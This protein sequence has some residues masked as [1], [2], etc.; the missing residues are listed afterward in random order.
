MREEG[1]AARA[2]PYIA[3]ALC[4]PMVTWGWWQQSPSTEEPTVGKVRLCPVSLRQAQALGPLISPL[5][6]LTLSQLISIYSLAFPGRS[7]QTRPVAVP[8]KGHQRQDKAGGTQAGPASKLLLR[9]VKKS[10]A[11]LRL[12]G[13]HDRRGCVGSEANKMPRRYHVMSSELVLRYWGLWLRRCGRPALQPSDSTTA[14]L[15]RHMD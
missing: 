4:F 14:S 3:P 10:L 1:K 5:Q 7:K 15:G 13:F 12:N 8:W 11:S 9:N 2:C 6:P